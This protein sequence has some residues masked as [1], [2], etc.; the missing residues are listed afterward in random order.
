MNNAITAQRAQEYGIEGQR[1]GESD[2]AFRDRVGGA[3]REAGHPIEAHEA[4]RNCL[5]DDPEGG[6][7]E[8]IIGA[9]ALAMNQSGFR[10]NAGASQLGDD[11]A[12]GLLV[13][14]RR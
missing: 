3:L 11:I 5:Y 12:A 8:G 1:E 7:M 6:A 2:A 14:R 10:P 9:V 4:L 13:R